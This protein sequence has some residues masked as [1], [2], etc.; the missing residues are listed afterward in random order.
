MQAPVGCSSTLPTA[1]DKQAWGD[2]P[3]AG[4]HH[5]SREAVKSPAFYKSD[6]PYFL[7]RHPARHLTGHSCID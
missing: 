2:T 3:T 4:Y 7:P 5:N 1:A 6:M